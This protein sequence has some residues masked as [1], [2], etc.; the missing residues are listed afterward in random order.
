MTHL[1]ATI[2]SHGLGHLAQTAPVLNALRRIQP[3]LCLTIASTLPEAR[4][5]ER[6]EGDFRLE[7]RALDFG[8]VM[9]DAF[10]IDIPASAQAYRDFHADWEDRVGREAE[11]LAGHRPDLVLANVAGLP[12][13]AAS[14]L[15]I[16]AVGM[17]SLNWADLFAH[18]F[19]GEAWAGP[20]HRQMIEAYRNATAFIR[21][22]PAM[23][24]PQLANTVQV[25]PVARIG[26]RRRQDLLDRL[27]AAP[28]EKVVIAAFGG[29][30][31]RLPM[32][33]W[34]FSA[35]I[36]WLVPQAWQF[37]HPQVAT[38]ESLGWDFTDLLASAD[39]VIGKP[40]YGTFTEAACNGT[41]MLYA[42]RPDW[43]EQDALIRWIQLHG[44]TR[45]IGSRDLQDG[46]LTGQLEALWRQPVP[47]PVLPDGAGQAASLLAEM[48]SASQPGG[49]L[50]GKA[51]AGILRR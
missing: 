51:P 22:T 20:I 15:G 7:H 39:A 43:P 34:S 14:R 16:P 29:I 26:K 10:R 41:P 45:E 32:E 38:I 33:N 37:D 48:L 31:A 46:N 30:D 6:I 5:R 19:A 1:V 21:L 4:L 9:E 28:N 44:H 49:D 2:S 27:G 3:G 12:L 35:G 13:A 24:M 42:L 36:R 25:G 8:F 40:G 11:W 17:S 18:A 50:T 23:E 47:V